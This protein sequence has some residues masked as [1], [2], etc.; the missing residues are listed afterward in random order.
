MEFSQVL[1]ARRS[2]RRFTDEDVPDEV[3][4]RVLAAGLAMPHA[5]NT[6][7]W[8]AIALRRPAR[9][10]PRWP[11]VFE[12]LLRQDYLA[13][14]PVLV[15]WAVQPQWWAERYR[16]NLEHLLDQG[17]VERSRAGDLLET[18]SAPPDPERLV[19]ALVGE[20]MLAVGAVLLA[21]V[22]AGLGAALA[23]CRP[24]ALAR[25]LDLP[26]QARIAPYGVLALGH[27]GVTPDV[28]PRAGSVGGLLRRRLGPPA[29]LTRAP[30][31]ARHPAVRAARGIRPG[32]RGG[33]AAVGGA[34]RG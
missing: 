23:G 34:A 27:P 19:P 24:G 33:A 20:A 4:R 32:R 28:R 31:G 18:V 1:G 11:G 14:A 13:E 10:H 6:Y 8:R 26:R 22:D 16:G 15:V 2:V 9:T 25:E 29:G 12:A 30:R 5:G 3:L 21:A 7:D 17:L